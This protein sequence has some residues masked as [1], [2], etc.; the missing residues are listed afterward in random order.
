MEPRYHIPG[1]EKFGYSMANRY[2]FSVNMYMNTVKRVCQLY[3]NASVK[4]LKGYVAHFATF[5]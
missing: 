4:D 3:Q 5:D 1:T 2:L